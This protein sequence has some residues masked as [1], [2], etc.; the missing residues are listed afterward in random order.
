MASNVNQIT[1]EGNMTRDPVLRTTSGGTPVCNFSIACN[2]FYK[3]GDEFEKETSFFDVQCW[4]G[5]AE[6]VAARGR[7]SSSV[8]ISGRLKQEK[9]EYEGQKRSRIIILA[10]NVQIFQWQNDDNRQNMEISATPNEGGECP[11]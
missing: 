6:E 10:F 8:R 11:F 9:W 1:V 7:K 2:R 5:M 4:G 3:K